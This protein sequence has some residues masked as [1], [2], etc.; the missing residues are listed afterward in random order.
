MDL[1]VKINALPKQEKYSKIL[2]LSIAFDCFKIRLRMAQEIELISKRQYVHIQSFYVK[3]I[4][5]MAGG[6]LKRN[7]TN[8]EK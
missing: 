3:E 8:F 2:E 6:W 4:G 5:E 1:L 7:R